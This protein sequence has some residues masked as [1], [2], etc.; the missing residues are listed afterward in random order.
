MTWKTMRPEGGE[1]AQAEQSA[2]QHNQAER[3]LPVDPR[4]VRALAHYTA[5]L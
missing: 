3:E 5:M 1:P 2:Q 4:H